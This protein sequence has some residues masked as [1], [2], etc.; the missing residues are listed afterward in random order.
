MRHEVEGLQAGRVGEVRGV[1]VGR[2]REVCVGRISKR[3]VRDEVV[4]TTV[5]GDSDERDPLQQLLRRGRVFVWAVGYKGESV[6]PLE[7]RRLD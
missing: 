5:V 6:L 3:E 7:A 4:E 1:G 2:E